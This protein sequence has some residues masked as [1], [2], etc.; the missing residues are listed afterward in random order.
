MVVYDTMAGKDRGSFD[1]SNENF[2]RRI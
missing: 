1:D 2:P